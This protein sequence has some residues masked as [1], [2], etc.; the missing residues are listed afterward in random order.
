MGEEG[1]TTV[2]A[3]AE[4]IQRPPNIARPTTMVSPTEGKALGVTPAPPGGSIFLL[5]GA[6][7]V[8]AAERHWHCC[9][10]EGGRKSSEGLECVKG[11]PAAGVVG[12]PGV[13]ALLE[14]ALGVTLSSCPGPA[15]A[16]VSEPWTKG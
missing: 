15:L 8:A 4:G 7:C 1:V 12:G 5:A 13:C 9:G 11:G 3:R 14:V 16:W 10:E 6:E 2:E